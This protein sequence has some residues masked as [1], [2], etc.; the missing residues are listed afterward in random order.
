MRFYLGEGLGDAT[1]VGVSEKVDGA[2]RKLKASDS[3]RDEGDLRAAVCKTE[4]CGKTGEA[5]ADNDGV[6][7][8]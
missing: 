1:R 4:S 8:R 6:S 2:L 5:S 3:L 7:H